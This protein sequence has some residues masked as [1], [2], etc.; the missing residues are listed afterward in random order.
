MARKLSK[1]ERTMDVYM[2]AGAEMRLFKTFGTKTYVAAERILTEKD[3]RCFG[4]AI[5]IIDELCSTVDASM[6]ED[7]PQIG[8]DYTKVFYG[9]SDNPPIN[10]AD[11][12]IRT[13]MKE[14]LESLLPKL[15][16]E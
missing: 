7:F 9:A 1:S 12:Q 8:H 3:R 13:Y 5:D 11:E 15:P 14:I 16:E 10:Q 6:F 4:K 2:K